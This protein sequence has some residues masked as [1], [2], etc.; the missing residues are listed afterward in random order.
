VDFEIRKNWYLYEDFMVSAKKPETS[1][2]NRFVVNLTT[3]QFWQSSLGNT[4]YE[5]FDVSY[6]NSKEVRWRSQSWRGMRTCK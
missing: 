4:Y 6:K 1:E 3:K 2:K 5:L